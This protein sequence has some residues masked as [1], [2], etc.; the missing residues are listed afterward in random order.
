MKNQISDITVHTFTSS[1]LS[2]MLSREKIKNK[3]YKQNIYKLH[4]KFKLILTIS[5]N[6]S[7]ISKNVPKNGILYFK[8]KIMKGIYRRIN[9]IQLLER[10]VSFMVPGHV[11]SYENMY[12][13]IK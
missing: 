1:I 5:V 2:Q 13:N 6:K 8:L 3:Y 9:I 11:K 12:R 7:V 10:G 4:V